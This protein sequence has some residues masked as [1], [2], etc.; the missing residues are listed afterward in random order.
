MMCQ[1]LELIVVLEV[2]TLGLCCLPA[3]A[4]V[5]TIHWGWRNV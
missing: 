2:A 3:I 4:L 1:A 5:I